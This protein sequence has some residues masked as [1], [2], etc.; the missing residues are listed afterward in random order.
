MSLLSAQQRIEFIGKGLVRP[1]CVLTG[2]SGELYVSHFGGGLTVI[3]PGGEQRDILAKDAGFDLQTNGFAITPNGDFLIA[4]LGENGGVWRL[5][6]DGS[7]APFLME[8]D[9]Q[10]LPPANFVSIDEEGGTWITVSTRRRPRTQ[11]YTAEI[12][13]GFLVYVGADGAWIAADGLGYTNEAHRRPGDDWIYVNETFAKQLSRFPI[14]GPG[15]LGPKQVVHRFGH[16]EFPDGLWF[17]E[18]G[19]ILVTCIISNKLIRI[20]ADGEASTVLEEDCPA[21]V[22][23]AEAAFQSGTMDARY[24]T[25]TPAKHLKNISSIAF[26]GLDRQDAY[27][28]CL[29]DD[30][31]VRTRME[32]PGVTPPAWRWM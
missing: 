15:R 23:D 17:D 32:C 25:Q 24:L 19:G 29:L 10:A 26:G 9:G 30:K 5:S 7:L 12:A 22:N 16:G 27:L 11:A 21:H 2:P 13:D 28:G 1:E 14:L 4:N 3:S 18:D 31:I 6:A 20:A 8:V